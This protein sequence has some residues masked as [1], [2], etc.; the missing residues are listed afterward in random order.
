MVEDTAA[1]DHGS[2]KQHAAGKEEDGAPRGEKVGRQEVA[3][4]QED[5]GHERGR[6]A[7]CRAGVGKEAAPQ[8]KKREKDNEEVDRLKGKAPLPHR[9]L[10]KI[11]QKGKPQKEAGRQEGVLKERE[12]GEQYPKKDQAELRRGEGEKDEKNGGQAPG[13]DKR[14]EEGCRDP[15]REAECKKDPPRNR[16]VVGRIGARERQRIKKK[17]RKKG[18]VVECAMHRRTVGG[19]EKGEKQKKYSGYALGREEGKVVGQKRQDK[20]PKKRGDPRGEEKERKGAQLGHR[21]RAE[22]GGIE[23]I[24]ERALPKAQ[25]ARRP[26]T[27]GLCP[28]DPLA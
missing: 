21:D 18:V 24:E 4:A 9:E 11:R 22:K 17:P 28:R 25:N 12:K 14:G 3:T 27:G 6:K 16:T 23:P 8:K 13:N 10:Q 2:R 15:E 19:K 7:G 26:K 5:D 20:T 1:G